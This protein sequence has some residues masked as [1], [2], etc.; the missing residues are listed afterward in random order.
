MTFRCLMTYLI[1][2]A[3]FTMYSIKQFK[4]KFTYLSESDRQ[5]QIASIHWFSPQNSIMTKR[6]RARNCETRVTFQVCISRKLSQGRLAPRH[7]GTGQ[8]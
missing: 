1:L 6:V 4:R 3:Y 5:I 7:Y 2:P 8:C